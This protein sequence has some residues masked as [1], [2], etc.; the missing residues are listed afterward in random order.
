[1]AKPNGIRLKA[2]VLLLTIFFLP[3]LSLARDNIRIAYPSLSSSVFY[4]MI[5]QKEGYYKE[6]GLNVE[7]L[8]V[9]GEI[10]IRTA[11]AGEVDYFT[12]AGS[13]LAGAVRDMPLK[14]IAVT[15]DRPSWDLIV[16]PQIKSIAQLRGATIGIMSPE[17]SL[18]VVTKEILR[19]NGLDPVKDVNLLIMGGDDVRLN[20]LR[21]KA[22][23]ATLFN[24]STSIRAQRDGYPKLAS[25]GQYVNYLQGGLTT[26]VDNIKQNPAKIARFMK[27]SLKGLRYYL[28]KREAAINY[29]MA[30]LRLSDR[31][32]AALLYDAES[33][34]MLRDGTTDEKILQPLIDDMKRVTKVNRDFKVSD[35]FDF[36]FIRKA[37]EELKSSGWKP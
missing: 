22:I 36:S 34:P 12:N 31:D 14:I 20:A 23:Q 33:K 2:R 9:R 16:Q 6:E 11:I 18:A 30:F 1:M 10:A 24:P 29:T 17:G 37:N 28:A 35:I 27:A 15:Q 21:G 7:V 5:A 13:A 8:S 19:Q 4:F 25:A 3:S 32:L 26:T